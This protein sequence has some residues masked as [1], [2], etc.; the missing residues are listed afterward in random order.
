MYTT[1]QAQLY[2]IQQAPHPCKCARQKHAIQ[3]HNYLQLH[4]PPLLNTQK[5]TA[6][7]MPTAACATGSRGTCRKHT[8]LAAHYYD[9]VFYA[10]RD[11]VNDKAAENEQVG[12][13][14]TMER[15]RMKNR[16]VARSLLGSARP[17]KQLHALI[18]AQI[19]CAR[20]HQSNHGLG[21]N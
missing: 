15:V 16:M 1:Y 9:R 5:P 3:V 14:C 18:A 20:I 17:S 13:H 21:T 2:C 11:Q 10:V 6:Q 4:T 8:A 12:L 7:E 19:A